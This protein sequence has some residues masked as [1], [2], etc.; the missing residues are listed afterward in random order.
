M[1][2]LLKKRL[3]LNLKIGIFDSGLGGL[4]T[5]HGARGAL[6]GYD[7]VYLG[8]TANLPYGDKTQEQI[9]KFTK[10]ALDYLFKHDCAIVFLFCN[11]ASARALRKLQR[12]GYRVLGIIIPMVEEAQGNRVGVLATQSTVDSGA[13]SRELEKAWPGV[14]VFQQAAPKLVPMIESGMSS[15]SSYEKLLDIYLKPL[16]AQNIDTLILG[17]THYAII[18][19]RIRALVPPSVR[20]ISQDELIGPKITDYLTRHPEIESQ[21]S[22]NGRREYFV[23]AHHPRFQNFGDFDRASFGLVVLHDRGDGATDR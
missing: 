7:V 21:L 17:C 14:Q 8:D 16:L 13:Y 3:T 9:Y 1:S 23:T 12:E 15:Y 18:K 22:R 2:F 4:I 19:D 6:A 11:S 5:M 20:A 10:R